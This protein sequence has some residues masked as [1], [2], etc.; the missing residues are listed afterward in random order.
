MKALMKIKKEPSGFISG[1]SPFKVFSKAR[2]TEGP[3]NKVIAKTDQQQNRIHNI[4]T[5]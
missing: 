2:D 3:K 5:N 1:L 4:L